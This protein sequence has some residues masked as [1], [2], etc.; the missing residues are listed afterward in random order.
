M[1]TTP[2]DAYRNYF[3]PPERFLFSLDG[4]EGKYEFTTKVPTSTDE[5]VRNF[6]HFMLGAG[7]HYKSVLSAFET[8]HQEFSEK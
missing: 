4:I 7:F 3:E 5:L 1:S 8:I 2:E 6:Y